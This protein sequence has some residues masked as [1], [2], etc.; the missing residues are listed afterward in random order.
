MTN[1]DSIERNP[2]MR[3]VD[4]YTCSCGLI[5]NFQAGETC[6]LCNGAIDIFA[7]K[8]MV[9]DIEIKLIDPDSMPDRSGA[10]N[11]DGTL[12]Y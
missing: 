7:G 11:A 2:R 5:K 4:T 12:K 10:F 9:P 6:P 1:P 8:E 3:E